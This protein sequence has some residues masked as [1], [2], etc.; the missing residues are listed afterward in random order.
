M[1]ITLETVIGAARH[2][3]PWFHK[4]RGTPDPVVGDYLADYQNTLIAQA[5]LRD[6]QFLSQTATIL[7]TLGSGDPATLA[8][9]GAD[10][11]LP[12]GVT[13]NVIASV[14]AA[15][16]RLV[17]TGLIAEDGATIVV[18][19]MAATSATSTSITRAGT[20]RSSD[21]DVGR[22][23]AITRG[24]GAGQARYVLSN[25]VDTWVVSDGTDGLE[26]ATTPDDTSVFSIVEPAYV[27]DGA[28]DTV[29]A[30]PATQRR[31]GYLVRLDE[32][33]D[34]FIDLSAPLVATLDVGVTLPSA[35]GITGGRIRWRTGGIEP[36]DFVSRT[37]RDDPTRWP[38]VYSIGNTLYFCGRQCD[39]QDVE[40]LEIEYVPVAPRFAAVSDYFLLPDAARPVLVAAGAECLAQR[41]SELPNCPVKVDY[42]AGQRQEAEAKFLEALRLSKRSRRQS[43]NGDGSYY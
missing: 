31:A 16:G 39:W 32:D 3:S 4:Q 25:T 29:L 40:Q 33:G 23:V 10:D 11:G 22:V 18:A 34:P 27:A 42:Y 14:A 9:A 35:S 30:M 26:W 24:T 41:A 38:A 15:A 17:E 7:L 21:E 20:T 5:C 36:L 13:D 43:M 1:A 37:Q 19:A 2:R 6:K 12:G 8:G 28:A